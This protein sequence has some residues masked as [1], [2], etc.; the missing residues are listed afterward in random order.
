MAAGS[1]DLTALASDLR[2]AGVN[3]TK[4]ISGLVQDTAKEVQAEAKTFAPY[5]T[6]RLASSIEIISETDLSAVIGP[7]VDYGV[8][9]EFGTGTRGEF[10][11]AKGTRRGIPAHPYMRPA[12]LMAMGPLADEMAQAGA[13]VIVKGPRSTL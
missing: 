6:G 12:L 9:Q 2:S 10:G 5:K 4:L 11:S 3:A 8:Y 7:T 13:L 1:A